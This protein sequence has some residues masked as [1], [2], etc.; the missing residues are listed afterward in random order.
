MLHTFGFNFFLWG[1]FLFLQVIDILHRLASVKRSARIAAEDIGRYIA[2][3]VHRVIVL[4]YFDYLFGLLRFVFRFAHR[5]S[6]KR[7]NIIGNVVC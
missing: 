5:L 4:R 1:F 3:T 6:V 2:L 7:Y